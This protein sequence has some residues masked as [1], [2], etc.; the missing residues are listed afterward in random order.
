MQIERRFLS[1]SLR[2]ETSDKGNFITGYAATFDN[3]SSDLGGFVEKISPGAFTRALKEKQDVRA[4]HNHNSDL[5][6]ARVS[7]GTLQLN[8]DRKGL[9]FRAKLA[10]TSYSDDLLANIEAGN[11]SECSFGFIARDEAWTKEPD[12]DDEDGGLRQVRTLKDCDLIDVSTCTF[13]AYPGTGV[14]ASSRSLWPQG[15]PAEVRSHLNQRAAGDDDDECDCPC[16]ECLAGDCAACNREGCDDAACRRAG[17]PEQEDDRSN[18]GGGADAKTKR[19]DGEDLPNSAFI[20]HG[21]PDDTSTWKLPVRFST[22]AKSESHVREAVQ[23][24]PTLKDVSDDEKERAWS[25]LK[26]IA[27]K[28]KVEVDDDDDERAAR[29]REVALAQAA[30]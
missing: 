29:A 22:L 16:S 15:M 10:E 30:W 26:A 5:I 27:K 25:E 28:Y 6:I 19:V 18:R 12:P 20:I 4:L 11:I 7:A 1:V 2:A 9:K 17:C 23:L 8:E 13:P 3:Y 14:G 24:F 21:D